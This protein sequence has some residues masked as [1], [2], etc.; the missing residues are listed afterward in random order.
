MIVEL[1]LLKESK[2][3]L[4]STQIQVDDPEI[5]SVGYSGDFNRGVEDFIQ[6]DTLVLDATSVGDFERKWKM[7]DV[8]EVLS[9][10]IKK[11]LQTGPV[12]ICADNGL[13][14]KLLARWIKDR[15]PQGYWFK[16]NSTFFQSL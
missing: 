11:S 7:D 8:L 13:S 15:Y 14:S 16:S 1:L 9:K 12:N 4:G 10:E 2:H 5:G 6:V 3:I